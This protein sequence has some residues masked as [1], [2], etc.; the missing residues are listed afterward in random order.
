[1]IIFNITCHIE[2]SIKLPFVAFAKQIV[3]D[4]S[5]LGNLFQEAIFLRLLT[6]I[7]DQTY[8]YTIQLKFDNLTNYQQFQFEKED[9]FLEILQKEFSGK[10]YTFTTLLEAV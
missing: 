8:T 4:G 10:I 3:L 1:M 9:Q 7:D 5:I 6:E 2:R